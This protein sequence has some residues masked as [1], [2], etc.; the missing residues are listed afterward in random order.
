[1]H[2]EVWCI[3]CKG[4]GH[5]KDHCLVFANYLVGGGPMPLRLEAYA[6]PSV[7]HA[8]MVHDLSDRSKAHDG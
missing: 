2:E 8:F 3:K 4:Q 1:V 5:D 6:G 7:T